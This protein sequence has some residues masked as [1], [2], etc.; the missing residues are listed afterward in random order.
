MS[1]HYLLTDTEQPFFYTLVDESRQSNHAGT[2][3]GRF[4]T[5]SIRRR[6]GLRL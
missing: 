3:A 6:S 4:T 5:S 1:A 2:A